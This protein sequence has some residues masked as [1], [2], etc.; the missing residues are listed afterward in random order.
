MKSEQLLQWEA[1]DLERQNA[2]IHPQFEGDEIFLPPTVDKNGDPIIYTGEQGREVPPNGPVSQTL[3]YQWLG[4]APRRGSLKDWDAPWDMIQRRPTNNHQY[5]WWKGA[6]WGQPRY[7]T[8][9]GV[10]MSYQA[11]DRRYDGNQVANN[12]FTVDATTVGGSELYW[13]ASTGFGAPA[14]SQSSFGTNGY[15]YGTPGNYNM[16]FDFQAYVTSKG[17]GFESDPLQSFLGIGLYGYPSGYL[18]G[19]LATRVE[20]IKY[21]DL[22]PTNQVVT[23][24]YNKTGYCSAST[25]HMSPVINA[26]FYNEVGVANLAWCKVWNMKVKRV[27]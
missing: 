3:L 13:E 27:S 10:G 23:G 7:Y 14:N 9:N 25:P 17:S 20:V 16:S 8:N 15:F 21:T 5:G 24:K 6:S 22:I 26:V 18:G 19:T 11:W 1:E 4:E 2:G 12:V